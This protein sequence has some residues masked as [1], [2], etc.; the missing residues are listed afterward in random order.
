VPPVSIENACC[1]GTTDVA[2]AGPTLRIRRT[3]RRRHGAGRGAF[4]ALSVW[5]GLAP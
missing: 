3:R 5:R 1:A 2:L 4:T